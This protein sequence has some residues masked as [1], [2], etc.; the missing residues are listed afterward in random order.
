M[1][2]INQAY[3]EFEASYN[4]R[5]NEVCTRLKTMANTVDVSLYK[6]WLLD[7]INFIEKEKI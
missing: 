2:E 4:K 7:T 3:D 5:K 1:E 6:K